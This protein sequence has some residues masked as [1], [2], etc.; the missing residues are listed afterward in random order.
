MGIVTGK[1]ERGMSHGGEERQG[2]R[3]KREEKEEIEG[4]RRTVREEL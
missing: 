3:R 1:S 4:D 2:K